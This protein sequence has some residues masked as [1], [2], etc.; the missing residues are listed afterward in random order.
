MGLFEEAD[1]AT[2]RFAKKLE[3]Q[4]RLFPIM[5]PRITSWMERN[6]LEINRTG[7]VYFG[8]RAVPSDFEDMTYLFLPENKQEELER[9]KS[10]YCIELS[11]QIFSAKD[12]RDGKTLEELSQDA[13]KAHNYRRKTDENYRLQNEKPYI[14]V[15]GI[16]IPSLDNLYIEYTCLHTLGLS[17]RAHHQ[18]TQIPIKVKIK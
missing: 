15:G 9:L 1:K 5:H 13:L 2:I 11:D 3:R 14:F 7:A 6:N 17:S 10:V 4:K 16:T 8:F 12:T 18:V